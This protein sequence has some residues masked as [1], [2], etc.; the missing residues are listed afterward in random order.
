M[1]VCV[2]V[3][4]PGATLGLVVLIGGVLLIVYREPVSR[5]MRALPNGRPSTPEASLLSGLIFMLVGFV[6]IWY[7]ISF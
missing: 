7:S 6:F 1:F 3:S 2:H 4:W 5:Q